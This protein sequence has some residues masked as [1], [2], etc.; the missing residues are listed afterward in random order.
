MLL[1][2]LGHDNDA[3]HFSR[4]SSSLLRPMKSVMSCSGT[5]FIAL[6]VFFGV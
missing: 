4:Y 6:A 3:Y 5:Y 2:D 1:G